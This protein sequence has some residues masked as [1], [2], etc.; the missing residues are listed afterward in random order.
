MYSMTWHC[1]TLKITVCC[2][3][4]CNISYLFLPHHFLL[5][6]VP[7]DSFIK[8]FFTLAMETFHVFHLACLLLDFCVVNFTY[9]LDWDRRRTDSIKILFLGV[10]KSVKLFAEEISIWIGRLRGKKLTF[11]KWAGFVKSVEH[12]GRMRSRGKAELF[13]LPGAGRS[14]AAALRHPSPQAP[15]LQ[16]GHTLSFSDAAAYLPAPHGTFWCH[17]GVSEFT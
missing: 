15:W 9:Q 6:L 8:F 5:R 16:L 1:I 4:S 14:S 7:L 2:T 10:A 17:N 11:V 12:I 13:A 3:H